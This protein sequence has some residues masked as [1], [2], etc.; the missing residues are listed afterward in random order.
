MWVQ[1]WILCT[2][3]TG[4][5]LVADGI[6]SIMMRSGRNVMGEQIGYWETLYGNIIVITKY[7]YVLAIAAAAII[8]FLLCKKYN[9]EHKGTFSKAAFMTYV[10]IAVLPFL[11]YA[12]SVN[13]SY[14]HS[15]MTYKSL[16]I[17]VFAAL[18]A[19]IEINN[20]TGKKYEE[21]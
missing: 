21:A 4:E 5:N 18:C 6:H 12:I 9:K 15:F 20:F 13:H 2:I 8:L 10:Y 11:W 17:T 16:S 7:P 19:F 14:I 3:F 1:K